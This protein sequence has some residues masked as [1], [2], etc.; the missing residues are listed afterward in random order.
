MFLTKEEEKMFEGEYGEATRIAMRLIVKVG[1]AL[2]AQKLINVNSAQVSGV[3]YKNLGD[4]GIQF[5]EDLVRSGGKSKILSTLNPAGMDLKNWTT[6]KISKEFAEK[7][8]KIINLYMKMD[9]L[10]TCSCIPYL[11]GN[12]PNY[13]EHIA[14]AESSAV[15][16]ANS[17]LGAKTNRE[18]GPLALASALTGKTAYYGLHLKENRFPTHY[19]ELKAELQNSTDYSVLGYLIGKKMRIGVPLFT[20][21]KIP[22]KIE[23]LKALSAGLATSG[24]ISIFHIENYTTEAIVNKKQ[25]QSEKDHMEKISIEEKDLKSIFDEYAPTSN[26][27]LIYIGCPHAG[28]QEIR[29]LAY[30]LRNKKI[31]RG[32]E[33][34]IGTAA[35]VKILAD[36][37]GY[38]DIIEKSG[39]KIITDTCIVVSP[40]KTLGIKRILTNSAKACYYLTGLEKLDVGIAKLEDCVNIAVRGM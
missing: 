25:H 35:N 8:L 37:I 5:L 18:G 31:R 26:P 20:D 1:E 14:W 23:D 32:L 34:W 28:I 17:V 39:G 40:L 24:S 16:Y 2:G 10:P 12:S 3:S 33:F 30:I 19:I 21:I 38:T 9:I 7:Q 11:I 15:T 36:R 29:K 4:P 13:N 6:M 22:P 27:D